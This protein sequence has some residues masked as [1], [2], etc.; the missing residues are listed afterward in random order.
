MY[1]VQNDKAVYGYMVVVEE[2]EEV[3]GGIGSVGVVMH[4]ATH[5]GEKSLNCTQCDHSCTTTTHL[6]QHMLRHSGARHSIVSCVTILALKV[7][8]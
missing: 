6:R 2:D 7:V 4:I 5:S 1:I 3:A 8:I